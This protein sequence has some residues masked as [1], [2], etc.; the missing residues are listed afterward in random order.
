MRLRLKVR[1]STENPISNKHCM[2]FDYLERFHDILG[3]LKRVV[4]P[5]VPE[6]FQVLNGY[7]EVAELRNISIDMSS[8]LGTD[9]EDEPVARAPFAKGNNG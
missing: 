5:K 4:P 1:V 8:N 3:K 7:E 9:T 6:T 2:F